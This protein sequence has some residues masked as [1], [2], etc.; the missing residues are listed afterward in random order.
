MVSRARLAMTKPLNKDILKPQINTGEHRSLC[1]E[2][3][4]EAISYSNE[5]EIARVAFGNNAM[6][7]E[8]IRVYSWLLVIKK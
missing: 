5:L 1:E 8:S 4:D 6:T 2:R 7:L 3:S